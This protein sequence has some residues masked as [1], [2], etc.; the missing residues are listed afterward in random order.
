[1]IKLNLA[2]VT[3]HAMGAMEER[4]FDFVYEKPVV[5]SMG[6]CLYVHGTEIWDEDGLVQEVEDEQQWTPGC[7]VGKILVDV[8]VPIAE[9]KKR[10]GNGSDTLLAAL[11]ED[12]V[13]DYTEPAAAFLS[14]VQTEQ[15]H[16]T[17]WGKAIMDAL[18]L[19][20]LDSIRN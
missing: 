10:D 15:D 11:K 7:L 3:A 1:M 4:G 8:G 20:A 12:G 18:R 2:N 9:L 5:N 16:G 19:R 14:D 6:G 13:L 17:E